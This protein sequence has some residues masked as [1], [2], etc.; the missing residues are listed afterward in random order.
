MLIDVDEI[1]GNGSSLISAPVVI[2]AK[3]AVAPVRPE[4]VFPAGD[5][6]ALAKTLQLAFADREMLRETARRCYAQVETNSPQRTVAATVEAVARGVAR[7]GRL[8]PP[9]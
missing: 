4:F 2:P 5:V 7:V 8:S 6:S 9:V 3:P 1:G